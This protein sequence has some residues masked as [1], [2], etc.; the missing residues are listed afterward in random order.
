MLQ[1]ESI[2]TAPIE[3]DWTETNSPRLMDTLDSYLVANVGEDISLDDL[4]A[5][6]KI[7]KFALTRLFHKHYQQAP[8]RW[9]WSYRAHLAKEVIQMDLGLPLMDVLTLCGFNSPQHFSRFFRKTFQ[10]TPS[11]LLRVAATT[12]QGPRD[13][14]LLQQELYQR[15]DRVGGAVLERFKA[16][17]IRGQS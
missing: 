11:A 14:L 1:A 12:P 3:A 5:A 2:N 7:S 17:F 13:L 8:M 4:A 6:V 9:L 10:Q 15:F 16:S